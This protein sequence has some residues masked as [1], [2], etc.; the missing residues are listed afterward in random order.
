[1]KSSMRSASSTVHLIP[2]RRVGTRIQYIQRRRNG[3]ILARA[4]HPVLGSI[5]LGDWKSSREA[6]AAVEKWYAAGGNPLRA[7]PEGILPKYVR[8]IS[9]GVYLGRASIRGRTILGNTHT[10][11]S[12]AHTEIAAKVL[13]ARR[14]A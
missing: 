6:N 11:P 9:P 13:R 3:L 1:M 10:T 4:W 14:R 8:E 5:Y 7:L 2:V 12:E